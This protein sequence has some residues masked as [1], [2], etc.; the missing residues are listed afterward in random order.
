MTTKA[1]VRPV[2]DVVWDQ[3]EADLA[4]APDNSFLPLCHECDEEC[5]RD[6]S[7]EI[8]Y[9]GSFLPGESIED[10]QD[11]GLAIHK[12]CIDTDRLEIVDRPW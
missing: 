1:Y 11:L 12:A 9:E 10:A 2:P 7:V 8:F 6:D 3:A 5:H 4:A